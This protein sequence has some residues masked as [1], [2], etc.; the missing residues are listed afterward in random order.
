[1]KASAELKVGIFALIVIGL[2]SVMTFWVGGFAWLRPQGYK[3]YVFL[4]DAS[5]LD[6]KTRIRVAGVDAG[7]IEDIVLADGKARLTLRMNPGVVLYSDATASVKTV[8]FLGEK[9]LDLT[10]GSEPPVLKDGDTITHVQEPVDIETMVRKFSSVSSDISKLVNN[11]NRV[12]TDREIENLRAA[13]DNLKEISA[14]TNA[15]VRANDKKLRLA[16]DRANKLIENLDSVVSQNQYNI[17]ELVENLRDVSE[18]LKRE[19]P[20]VLGNIKNTTSDIKDMVSENKQNIDNIIKKADKITANLSEGKGTL[21]KLL[22]DESLYKNVNKGIENLNETLGAIN[23]FRVFLDFQGQYLTKA[24]DTRGRFL[25]T[26]QPR[27]DKYYIIGVTQNPI[28]RLDKEY[29]I[30]DGQVVVTSETPKKDIEFIAQIAHRFRNTAFRIGVMD[31][32]FG[33]GADQFF[34]NDK[35]KV[36]IDAYDFAADEAFAKNAHVTVG[37]DYFLFKNIY[38]SA[39]YD[40]ILNSRWRGPYFGGG[41]RFEDRD[42]KYLLGTVSP[43]Y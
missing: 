38:L 24:H 43:K 36:F 26:L 5:G 22:T 21:G 3:L 25:L 8:G 34:Y 41:L 19:T 27:P 13:I 42:L 28:A 6:K 32:T 2:L 37:A 17:S 20:A 7:Y 23:R 30:S 35:L 29:G 14:N 10:T 11:V 9:Y 31:N 40:N 1:M 16:L 39:G 33:L 15:A 18:T 12:F 4:G